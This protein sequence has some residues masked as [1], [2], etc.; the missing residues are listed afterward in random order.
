MMHTNMRQIAQAL[1][2]FRPEIHLRCREH[3]IIRDV[4]VIGRE[5][6]KYKPD[7]LYI[8]K[9]DA[10][11]WQPEDVRIPNLLL[12]SNGQPAADSAPARL[13]GYRNLIVIS[14]QEEPENLRDRLLALPPG[15]IVK[16]VYRRLLDAACL[17]DTQRFAADVYS[18]WGNPVFIHDTSFRF[19][20]RYTGET[21]TSEMESHGFHEAESLTD[22]CIKFIRTEKIM[23]LAARKRGPFFI[24]NPPLGHRFLLAPVVRED[25]VIA[26]LLILEINSDM[27]EED[28]EL[29]EVIGKL[30]SLSLRNNRQFL[31]S[32]GVLHEQFFKDLASGTLTKAALMKRVNALN[33]Q[34]G[35]CHYIGAMSRRTAPLPRSRLTII[36]SE[37]Q[38]G[39]DC[40]LCMRYKDCLLVLVSHDNPTAL[41]SYRLSWLKSF[42]ESY[43]LTAAFS[44]GFSDLT[45]ARQHYLQAM[46]LLDYAATRTDSA[47]QVFLFEDHAIQQL[48]F[49]AVP[50]DVRNEYL[51]P[52][53]R[54]VMEY[55]RV[56][57]AGL[58]E[59]LKAYVLNLKH[60][61]STA[62]ALNIHRNT[63]FY[64]LRSLQEIYPLD[65]YDAETILRL[66]FSFQVLEI[67]EHSEDKPG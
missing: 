12:L 41:S 2:Q 21:A 10:R 5:A 59:T 15:D 34:L 57:N 51:H 1:R 8:A 54:A 64:R 49:S 22:E 61:N 66:M 39:L 50:D 11:E 13:G 36:M 44:H 4:R 31:Y 20:A 60:I 40:K 35:S 53:V 48:V 47:G 67:M 42:L 63:L 30:F 45:S 25:I 7:T 58:L 37:L 23:E 19:I 32:I 29:A 14:T 18:I 62:Q 24:S 56:H 16:D 9:E 43:G 52:A 6:E 65:F 3:E 55:D 33:V 38:T 28:L 27:T 46:S 17:G 26:A